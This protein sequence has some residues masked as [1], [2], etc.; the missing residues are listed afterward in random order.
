MIRTILVPIDGS[1]PSHRALEEA[2]EMAQPLGASLIIL[3]VIE[4]FGPLPGKYDA[5]PEGQDRTA[6]LA[7]ERFESVRD[8]LV[9]ERVQWTRVIEEGYPAELICELAEKQSVDLV[10]MGHRGLSAVARIVIG[11]VSDKVVRNAPCSVMVVR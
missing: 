6:W 2:V 9:H 11:S 4:D 5:A 8:V 3:E 10:V 1:E 7:K